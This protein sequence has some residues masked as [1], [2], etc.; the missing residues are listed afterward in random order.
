MIDMQQDLVDT[1]AR[2][3]TPHIIKITESV[4]ENKDI[5]ELN[6]KDVTDIKYMIDLIRN[7]NG[8]MS[9]DSVGATVYSYW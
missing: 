9:E 6:D 8:E 4:L 1:I 5:Y 2:D 7:F 3:I